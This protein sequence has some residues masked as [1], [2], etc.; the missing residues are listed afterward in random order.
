MGDYKTK[1]RSAI[2]EYLK[3][4][5][6][7]RFTARDVLEAIRADGDGLDRSTVYRNLE[8]LCREGILIKY[9]EADVSAACYQY[10]EGHGSCHEHLHAQCVSC[11]RIFHL[12]NE[13]IEDTARKMHDKYGIDIDYKTV[14]LCTCKECR[15]K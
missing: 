7:T 2:I 6:D 1:P 14:L 3:E 13:V 10:S 5:A 8:R 12:D 11:G 4:N 9:K 15:E